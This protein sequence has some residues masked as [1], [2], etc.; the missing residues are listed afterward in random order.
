MSDCLTRDAFRAFDC[1]A[2]R[3]EVEVPELAGSV[4]IRSLTLTE[5]N[6]IQVAASKSKTTSIYGPLLARAVCDD[7]GKP[8]LEVGDVR[9][10]PIAIVT[11]LAKAAMAHNGID[12]GGE[13]R[14]MEAHEKN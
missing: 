8:I 13:A 2:N 12:D 10:L 5:V 11:R 7:E 14:A 4:W 1:A 9:D 3:I 6:E